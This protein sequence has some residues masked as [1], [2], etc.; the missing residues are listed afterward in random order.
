MKLKEPNPLDVLLKRRVGFCPTHFTTTSLKKRYNLEGAICDW[1]HDN[2]KGRY[3]F[4]QNVQLNKE[5]NS[6]GT[7]YTVGFENGKELSYFMLAC[8]HLKYN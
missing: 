8:P 5:D 3:F 1:I 4:G 6:L 7:V 2:L